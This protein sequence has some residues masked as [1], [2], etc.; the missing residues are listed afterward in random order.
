MANPVHGAGWSDLTTARAATNVSVQL[1]PCIGGQVTDKLQHNQ[2]VLRCS[3]SDYLPEVDISNISDPLR[4]DY[5]CHGQAFFHYSCN[6]NDAFIVE[7]LL[8]TPLREVVSPHPFKQEY[9]R[10]AADDATPLTVLHMALVRNC[11]IGADRERLKDTCTRPRWTVARDEYYAG[12]YF[13]AFARVVLSLAGNCRL[14]VAV[15]APLAQWS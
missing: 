3:P 1:S 8:V 7:C 5:L 15:E 6:D 9:L 12:H 13:I 4:L 2:L 11:L 10:F 14:E